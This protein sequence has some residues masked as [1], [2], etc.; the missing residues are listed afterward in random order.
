MGISE[1]TSIVAN[2]AD[3]PHDISEIKRKSSFD[4]EIPYDWNK[5]VFE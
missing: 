4:K 1:Q 2:C 3:F 5:R